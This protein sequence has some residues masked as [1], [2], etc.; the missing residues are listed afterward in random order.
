MGLDANT[1]IWIGVQMGEATNPLEN[2]PDEIYDRLEDKGEIQVAGLDFR[3]FYHADEPVGF[4]VELLDR[5][6]RDGSKELDLVALNRKVQEL[7]PRIK[8]AFSVLKITVE[9]KVWLG[10]H[11]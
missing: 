8:T 5:G 9:P 2:A 10:T 7:M 1:V 3:K 6:W 4:G 11:L